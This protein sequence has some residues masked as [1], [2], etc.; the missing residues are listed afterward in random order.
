MRI[1]IK[2]IVITILQAIVFIGVYE[3]ILFYF[4]KNS[5]GNSSNLAWGISV[6]F[7]LILYLVLIVVIN[8]LTMIVPRNRFSKRLLLVSGISVFCLLFI[9]DIK[10]TPYKSF[11]LITCAVVG[12]SSRLLFDKVFFRH[13]RDAL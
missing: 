1:F 8:I 5:F 4:Q 9:D 3:L 11:A 10:H 2:L 12:L 13:T 7:G 6:Q